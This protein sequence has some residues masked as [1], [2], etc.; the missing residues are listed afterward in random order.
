MNNW[1]EWRCGTN[2]TN[3][4]SVLK[5]LPPIGDGTNMVVSWQS[6]PGISYCLERCANLASGIFTRVAANIPGSANTTSFTDTNAA[7]GAGFFY[8]VVVGE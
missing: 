6:V 5:L 1:Q 8:R 7:P 3:A 2:P 4:Q